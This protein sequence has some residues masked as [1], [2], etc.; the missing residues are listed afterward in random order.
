MVE[1]ALYYKEGPIS[2]RAI[3]EVQSI[4]LQ[5]LE[6][7]F[8]RLKKKTL[9]RTARGPKGGYSLSKEPSRISV[10]SIIEAL[11]DNDFLADCLRKDGKSCSHLESCGVR[12]FWEKLDKT[13]N[14]ML[15]ST[16]LDDLCQKTPKKTKHG[17]IAHS[18][19]FQI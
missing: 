1:L 6:Q 10:S 3:S 4:P 14:N 5:Y 18:Y 16:T 11:E 12:F 9:V 15:T 19:P 13:I 7:I 2:A 17:K 8:N